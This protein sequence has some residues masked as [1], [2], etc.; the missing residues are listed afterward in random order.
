MSGRWITRATGEEVVE[1]EGCF[2]ELQ[3][4]TEMSVPV[5]GSAGG[6]LSWKH[7]FFFRTVAILLVLKAQ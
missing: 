7:V 4:Q 2:I 1:G 6:E 3:A 5:I